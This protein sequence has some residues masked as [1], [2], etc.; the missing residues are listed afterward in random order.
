MPANTKSTT[1]ILQNA[2]RVVGTVLIVL[3]FL[4]WTG[5]AVGLVRLHMGLGFVL[6]AL[7]WILSAIG[8]RARLPWALV[9]IS[10]AWG[11]L[12][13]VLGMSMGRILPGRSHELARV[14][15]FFIGLIAIGLSE[16][17]GLRIKRRTQ[18]FAS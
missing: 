6:V 5:H 9:S 11:V 4:F 14:L 15:H 10:I 8:A 16:S 17:L 3:G 7:L 18:C 1:L 12:V 2:V 13:V